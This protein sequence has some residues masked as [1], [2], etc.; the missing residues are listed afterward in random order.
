MEGDTRTSRAVITS[1][2]GAV[3]PRQCVDPTRVLRIANLGVPHEPGLKCQS[4]ARLRT[5]KSK[6][7]KRLDSAERMGEQGKPLTATEIPRLPTCVVRGT[8]EAVSENVVPSWAH[9][10]EEMGYECQKGMEGVKGV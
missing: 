5:T 4:L 3:S 10:R 2:A 6:V 9:I 8:D 7:K 1:F